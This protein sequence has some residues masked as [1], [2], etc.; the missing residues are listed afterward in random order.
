MGNANN[1]SNWLPVKD[2]IQPLLTA[3]YSHRL[4][5]RSSRISCVDILEPMVERVEKSKGLYKYYIGS[6]C[7][8]DMVN[9]DI[10]AYQK[11]LQENVF[12]NVYVIF[13]ECDKRTFDACSLL[14]TIATLRYPTT[15]INITCEDKP[16]VFFPEIDDIVREYDVGYHRL[17]D[18]RDLYNIISK[19]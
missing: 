19:Y 1:T 6:A 11:L 8:W 10:S 15:L 4:I 13:T 14:C 7:I 12:V 5:L 3:N 16:E 17:R 18:Y 2:E 9:P